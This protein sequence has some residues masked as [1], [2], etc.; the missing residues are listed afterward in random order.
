MQLNITAKNMEMT[1]A[2]RRAVEEKF[3]KVAKRLPKMTSAHVVLSVEKYRNSAELK[4]EVDRQ[5]LL[6]REVSDD[7]YLSID[8]VMDTL[9]RKAR[10]HREK[11]WTTKRIRPRQEG[12]AEGEI[13]LEASAMEASNT[14]PL[15][16][17]TK[18]FA[19]KPMSL[20]E[21]AMQMSLIE[22]DFLVFANA[23]TNQVNVIYKRKDGSY[24]LIEP[25]FK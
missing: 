17:K 6:A 25:V 4:I 9:E 11:I 16:V 22:D 3:Q 15:I 2:L 14:P 24:G 5:T 23:I 7:M 10:R 20:E 1:D 19:V 13:V 8:K 21:A 12:N 18:R